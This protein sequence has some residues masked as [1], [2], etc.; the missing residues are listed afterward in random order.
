VYKLARTITVTIKEKEKEKCRGCTEE[1][2]FLKHFRCIGS[3]L[4]IKCEMK[5]ETKTTRVAKDIKVME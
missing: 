2:N 3:L 1:C 5:R 4:P